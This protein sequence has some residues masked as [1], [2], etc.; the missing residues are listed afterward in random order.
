MGATRSAYKML[1]GR[2]EGK[3]PL[4]RKWED[5]IRID[6]KGKTYVGK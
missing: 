6:L 2:H 5:N 3:R 1:I 4:M